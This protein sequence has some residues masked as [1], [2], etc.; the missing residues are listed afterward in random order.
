MLAFDGFK[1]GF[2]VAF[3]E[4]AGAVALDQLGEERRAI[5][6]RLAEDLQQVAVVVAVG[7]DAELF[8]P[9]QVGGDFLRRRRRPRGTWASRPSRACPTTDAGCCTAVGPV[10]PRKELAER[11][12][13]SPPPSSLLVSEDSELEL[14]LDSRDRLSAGV[15]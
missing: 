5:L 8:E 10:G 14:V 7:Q 1:Q 2:E 6:H 11:E 12:S 4:A 13:S 15:E 9:R 3:A